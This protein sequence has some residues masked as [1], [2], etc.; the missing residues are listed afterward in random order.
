MNS[1]RTTNLKYHNY[2]EIERTEDF[3]LGAHV[4]AQL[5]LSDAALGANISGL[6]FTAN[7]GIG[8]ATEH[9]DTLVV[10]GILD[11]RLENGTLEN[12]VVSGSFHYFLKQSEQLLLYAGSTRRRGVISTSKIRSFSAATADCAVIR[13]AIRMALPAPL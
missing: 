12:T 8:W 2:N 7:G 13:C 5:G 4:T 9:N 3:Y 1:S 11:G 10:S 6:I